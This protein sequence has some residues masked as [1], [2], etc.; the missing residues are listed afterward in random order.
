MVRGFRIDSD[1]I[2]NVFNNIFLG[3]CLLLVLYPIIYVV[4]ASF[5]STNAIMTGRVWLWPVD[6]S[7]SGYKAVF[8]YEKVWVGYANS[9]IYAVV[10]T[11]VNVILTILAAYPL[12]RKDFRARNGIMFL[13]TFTMIF[14]G[15]MIP[16][17]LVVRSLGLLNTRAAL[18]LPSAMGVWHVIIARTF[19]QRSLSDELLEA[20]KVEGCSDLQFVR[21]IVIPLSKSITAVL[22][23]YYAVFHWNA[24]FEA[25]LYL[26]NDRL[27]PLQVILR[28]ILVMNQ[29]DPAA[30]V[31]PEL[32]AAKEGMAELLKYA[33]IIVASVPVLCLY[34]FVQRHFVKGV[35]IGAIKG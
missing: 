34:P 33:L 24:F 19:Y 3:I 6:F 29:I 16:T 1:R 28:D 10:G 27:Y 13:F 7:L 8:E 26:S 31:D 15:G 22:C 12:S 2:Y 11:T 25:F 32:Q 20:A 23:L 9:V 21:S 17:Y 18:I 35:M 5:S 4:S 14:Q 30:M